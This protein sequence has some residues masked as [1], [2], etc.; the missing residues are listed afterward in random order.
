MIICGEAEI[1]NVKKKKKKKLVNAAQTF[2]FIAIKSS[3]L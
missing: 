1:K 2:N 3:N